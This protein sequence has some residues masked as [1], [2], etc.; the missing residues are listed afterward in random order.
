MRLGRPLKVD[1][2][3][4]RVELGRLFRDAQELTSQALAPSTW[5][6][7]SSVHRR[8]RLFLAASRELVPRLDVAVA[9]GLFVC[10]LLRRGEVMGSSALT[11]LNSLVSAERRLGGEDLSRSQLI[12]DMRRALRRLGALRPARQAVPITPLQ[13]RRAV[14]A[15][16]D[17]ETA[18]ALLLTWRSGARVG[19]ALRLRGMDVR[20]VAGGLAVGWWLTK[21]DPFHLGCT[22]AVAMS[23]GEMVRFRHLLHGGE[24]PLFPRTTKA[25]I[26]RALKDVDARL[27][28]RSLRRG[29]LH[30]LLRGGTPLET[31]REFSNHSSVAA[32]L[33]YLPRGELQRVAAQMETSRGLRW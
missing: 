26:T 12:G 3:P 2:P 32:L 30:A 17:D 1:A 6:A 23:P 27:T 33:R 28:C 29:A 13:A 9:V 4:S 8:F 31:I 22:S 24:G 25:R 7:M 18:F 16:T 10:R 11:Y 19:D 20:E 14:D 21:S 5:A 15:A